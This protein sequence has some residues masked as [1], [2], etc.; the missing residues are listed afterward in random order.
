MENFGV[1]QKHIPD[2]V[3]RQVVT[4]LPDNAGYVLLLVRGEWGDN[5]HH[6]SQEILGDILNANH[7]EDSGRNKEYRLL[8]DREES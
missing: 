8:R 1:D 5:H 7:D 4:P 6:G 3:P 2:S